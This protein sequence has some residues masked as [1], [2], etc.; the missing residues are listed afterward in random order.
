M[1]INCSFG[2]M[3][4]FCVFLLVLGVVAGTVIAN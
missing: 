1:H 2:A 4:R 3:V